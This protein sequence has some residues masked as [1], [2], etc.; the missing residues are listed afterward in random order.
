VLW[1][2]A[3]AGT[4]EGGPF[5]AP[6][7]IVSEHDAAGVVVRF[8]QFDVD[9]LDA[10]LERF[11][12]LRPDPFAIPPNAAMRATERTAELL[13]A[14]DW[15]AL[16]EFAGPGFVFEDRRRRAL[17]SGG[18]D[19]WLQ[20]LQIVASW[21]ERRTRVVPVATVGGRIALAQLH[22]SIEGG[23]VEGEF[24]RLV[25]VDED[26]RLVAWI[27]FDDEDRAAALAE[28]NARGAT[29]EAARS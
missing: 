21:P 10:A 7:I 3:W 4:R 1:V 27:H 25:E 2:A 24:L 6:W 20:N 29:H 16:R 18:V 5:E 9:G 28:T 11:A 15:P 22:Y 26:G 23:R 17:V 13:A 8:H 19:L 14:Q 12:A